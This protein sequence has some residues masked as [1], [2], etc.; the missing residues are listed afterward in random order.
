MVAVA[1][2]FFDVDLFLRMVPALVV[3]LLLGAV[4]MCALGLAVGSL[5]PSADAGPALA[6]FTFLPLAFISD[7]FFPIDNAPQWLQTLG[8]IFPVK[9]FAYA[10]QAGFDPATP[11]A[12]FQWGHLAVIAAWGVAGALAAVRWFSWEP[13]AL[14]G[15]R[16]SATRRRR[17][18]DQRVAVPTIV[19]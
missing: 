11:G 16:R 17:A 19:D 8:W 5:A 2:V 13:K 3:T 15:T 9:H 6:N 18:S 1:V 7:V 10:M 12:G 4:C 14:P